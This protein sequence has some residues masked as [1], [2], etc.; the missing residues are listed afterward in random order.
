MTELIFFQYYSLQACIQQQQ[1]IQVTQHIDAVLPITSTIATP[2]IECIPACMPACL[3]ECTEE[4]LEITEVTPAKSIETVV[5]YE[6]QNA[7]LSVLV[8]NEGCLDQ[9]LRFVEKIF[10]LLLFDP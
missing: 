2:Q 10:A 8:S 4:A 7:N 5:N 6:P 1:T 9:C 3:P